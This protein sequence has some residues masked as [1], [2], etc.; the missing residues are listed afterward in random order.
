MALGVRRRIVGDGVQMMQVEIHIATGS[1]VPRH[2][3]VH[4][5]IT[6]MVSGTLDFALGET[7]LTLHAGDTLV[8]P[9][10]IWHSV[11]AVDDVVAIDTFSPPREDFR[12]NAPL[13][14]AIYGQK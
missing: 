14:P 2:R 13:D 6:H 11:T 12:S 5:Q 9:S 10:N 4:E 1:A 8:I 7:T 3:H